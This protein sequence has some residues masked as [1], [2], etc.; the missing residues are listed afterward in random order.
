[1]K[2]ARKMTKSG[3]GGEEITGIKRE[4]KDKYLFSY[5]LIASLNMKG[6]FK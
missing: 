5:L 2:E 4:K 6:V 3:P 1:M